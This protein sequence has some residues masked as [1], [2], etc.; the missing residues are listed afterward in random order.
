MLKTTK[1]CILVKCVKH[2]F[3]THKRFLRSNRMGL[4]KSYPS[5]PVDS[6]TYNIECLSFINLAQ[7]KRCCDMYAVQMDICIKPEGIRVNF[8]KKYG[9]TVKKQSVEIQNSEMTFFMNKV[10]LAFMQVTGTMF[11]R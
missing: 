4:S 6:S 7:L 11:M 3:D 2:I 5:K 8:T 10:N 1:S 9:D